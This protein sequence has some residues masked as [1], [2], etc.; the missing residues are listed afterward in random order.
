MIKDY[1][2]YIEARKTMNDN[3]IN[4]IAYTLAARRSN[5]LWRASA[6]VDFQEESISAS[7]P[8][9]SSNQT[10]IAY[11]FTGQGTQYAH[12]GLDLIRYP[13]YY[14]TLILVNDAL[15]ELGCSWNLFSKASRS[16]LQIRSSTY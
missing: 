14:E 1:M 13:V 15:A 12:M 7:K 5:L 11:V 9:R 6:V 8:R 2:S 16:L 4:K 3:G 10:G